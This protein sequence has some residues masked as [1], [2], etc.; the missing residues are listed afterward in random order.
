MNIQDLQKSFIMSH[1]KPRIS[2]L[3]IQLNTLNCK[4]LQLQ[5]F[6][7]FFTQLQQYNSD[8]SLGCTGEQ[9]TFSNLIAIILE[10]VSYHSYLQNGSKPEEFQGAI[11]FSEFSSV[12]MSFF[13]FFFC[14]FQV[15]WG[16]SLCWFVCVSVT[17]IFYLATW[18][19]R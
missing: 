16:G 5:F 11:H 9:L 3:V 7:F 4:S 14:I 2:F 6:H 8:T 12:Q 17:L 1:N 19:S 15:F 18:M 13:F 10:H